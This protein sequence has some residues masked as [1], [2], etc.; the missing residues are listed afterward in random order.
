ME[1]DA[2]TP[3]NRPTLPA[4]RGPSP[5]ARNRRRQASNLGANRAYGAFRSLKIGA[6]P[7]VYH[8]VGF[9]PGLSSLSS[10]NSH[11]STGAAPSQGASG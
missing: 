10:L 3:Q 9:A 11:I 6:A 7:A 5:A 1:E 2:R 4:H 8:P